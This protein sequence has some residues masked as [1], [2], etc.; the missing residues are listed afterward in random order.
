MYYGQLKSG[1]VDS[2]TVVPHYR[3]L[4]PA[5]RARL[6]FSLGQS[7]TVRAFT[8]AFWH[9]EASRPEVTETTLVDAIFP[10]ARRSGNSPGAGGQVDAAAPSAMIGAC[11]IGD[12]RADGGVHF[13]FRGSD[14]AA[15][16]GGT[17][18]RKDNNVP[19]L[20][21][22]AYG[23]RDDEYLFSR[24][25]L[26]AADA[27]TPPRFRNVPESAKTTCLNAFLKPLR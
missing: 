26:H 9:V 5:A 25:S 1:P 27:V 15:E 22:R 4:T 11:Q 23:P 12:E 10:F 18:R 6:P 16:E 7:V 19:A 24:L 21:R 8:S 20:Q 14:R 3:V 13:A 17:R 2:A